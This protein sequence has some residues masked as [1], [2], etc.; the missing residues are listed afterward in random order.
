MLAY[1]KYLTSFLTRFLCLS[2]EIIN[3]VALDHEKQ[4]HHQLTVLVT[5]HG[6]PRLNTTAT[7]YI[8]VR[9]LNDNRP[10]FP[11]VVPGREL[12]LKVGAASGRSALEQ[13]PKPPML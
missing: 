8:T 2:G 4:A 3:W 6:S 5:D 12:Q 9:D 1:G 7:V 10:V 11:G 13:E